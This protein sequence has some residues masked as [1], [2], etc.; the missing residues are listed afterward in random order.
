MQS[1]EVQFVHFNDVVSFASLIQLI[2]FS[3]LHI[4]MRDTFLHLQQSFA[5][6]NPK[7]PTLTIFSGDAF[8]PS[9]EASVLQGEQACPLLDLVKVDI[10][11][12]GNHDFDFGE[13]RLIELSRL[14]RFPWL[15]SNAVHLGAGA[16]GERRLLASA[17]EYIVRQLENGLRVGF[18][19]LAGSDWPSQCEGLPPCEIESP[20]DVA[21]RLARHL[22]VNEHC[23]LVIALTHLRIPED[24]AVANATATG[25]SRIDLLLGGHDHDVVR[26]FA[27]DTDLIAENVEHGRPIAEVEAGGMVP[28]TE[29]NIRL[30]KSGTDWRGLSLIQLIVQTDEKGTIVGSTVKLRQYTDIQADITTP[31]PPSPDV[32]ETIQAI[33]DRVGTLVQKPLL[34]SAIPLDG[35]NTTLR[36]QETNM[37]NMLADTIRA[38]YDT[39]I[40]F[41]NS[42]A[43]RADQVVKSTIPDGKALL[44]RDIINICPFGNALL[45]KQL[46]GSIIQLALEN[47]VSDSHT[48][49]RFLQ[50]SGMKFVASWQRPEGSRVIE[51]LIQEPNGSYEPLDPL[52]TY[53]VAMPS[54]IAQGYDGFSWFSKAKTIVGEEAALSDTNLMLNIF[55]HGGEGLAHDGEVEDSPHVLGIER[56]RKAIVVEHHPVDSFPI[57]KPV[58]EGRIRFVGA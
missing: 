33:H 34:H 24:M 45:V 56:A 36:S 50:I 49:G 5:T 14:S 44:V 10:G 52:R 4:D 8:S 58:V 26:R 21:R 48:D 57:V 13:T 38:F 12:Y 53:T 18:I 41:F 37:G 15:L 46:P 40:G 9:L 27:G 42:G 19:G 43:T 17:Q 16:Q 20:V 22:R 54:F 32:I 11:C 29:G 31:P 35:R 51:I 55:G 47:A 25:E 2:Y 1:E 28:D 3:M 6:S 39:D 7:A 23:D 30:I